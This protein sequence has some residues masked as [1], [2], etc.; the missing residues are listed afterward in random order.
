MR[1]HGPSNYSSFH[2]LGACGAPANARFH[3]STV[4][5]TRCRTPRVYSLRAVIRKIQ[6]GLEWGCH[7]NEKREGQL[8]SE[9][10]HAARTT[11][12]SHSIH[13]AWRR[14]QT[15]RQYRR[16]VAGGARSEL[17]SVGPQGV[18]A[19]PTM[20]GAVARPFRFATHAAKPWA[21]STPSGAPVSSTLPGRSAWVRPG[22]TVPRL[23][24]RRAVTA[25]RW[26]LSSA[27]ETDE[28]VVAA[29]D[30][31]AVT[32]RSCGTSAE[33]AR[34]LPIVRWT[35]RTLIRGGLSH[36]AVRADAP[37][38]RT[39]RHSCVPYS[40]PGQ[41][42]CSACATLHHPDHVL[43]IACGTGI[44][45][46]LAKSQAV[47]GRVV[48]VDVNP[49][50]LAV[51][52]D[53]SPDVD[54][55]AGD[56]TAL[57]RWDGCAQS[58][59]GRARPRYSGCESAPT[60]PCDLEAHASPCMNVAS[61]GE[62]RTCFRSKDRWYTC[63]DLTTGTV[64]PVL[65]GIVAEP[66]CGRRTVHRSAGP[67]RETRALPASAGSRPRRPSGRPGSRFC[68]EGPL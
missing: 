11:D 4:D 61:A 49:A 52:R 50:M 43:D 47:T 21:C 32:P 59:G 15:G 34:S 58:S 3:R 66:R 40:S 1:A 8:T 20:S 68:R 17:V 44:V 23:P 6:D 33:W 24:G 65:A 42:T 56:S 10:G 14:Q 5:A 26:V 9:R 55:R 22:P 29:A 13:D 45:A 67:V 31:R 51:A 38:K 54:W 37:P 27:G 41:S 36:A 18:H 28:Q 39:S 57:P 63:G 46:R 30:F 53:L 2:D 64:D 16:E 35:A 48:G 60:I 62:V 19:E 25:A 7:E 12:S